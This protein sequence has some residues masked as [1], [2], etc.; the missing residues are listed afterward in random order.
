MTARVLAL[1][2][3]PIIR[4]VHGGQRRV[5]AFKQFYESRGAQYFHA[6][7]YNAAHYSATDV[8]ADDWPL[9]VPPTDTGLANLIGDLMS[10][11][12]FERDEPTLKHFVGVLERID[13]DILQ[14]EHPFMW[15]LARR[16]RQICG[17]RELC[18]VYS[19]HNVEAPLKREILVSQ[20]VSSELRRKICAEI[21]EIEAELCREADLVV[22]VSSA[23]RA[24]YCQSKAPADVVIV[25]NGVDRPPEGSQHRTNEA[26]QRTFEGRRFV[27]TVGS[28]HPPNVDGTCHYLVDGGIFCVPPA[29]SIAVC[30]GV[31]HLLFQRSEFQRYLRANSARVEFFP[32]LDDADLWAIKHACHGVILPLRSGGGSNLKTAEALALGKWTIGTLVALRGYEWLAGA[33]GVIIANDRSSFRHAMRDVLQRPPLQLTEGDRSA[34]EALFWDRCFVDSGVS[35]ILEL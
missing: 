9:I 10:G 26:V 15:P 20:G 19:S 17:N 12:Q 4:P 21:E 24:H 16:L 22:C 35:Q 34:R 14:V 27:M 6:C 31:S 2:T 8:G 7:I 29:K 11:H 33:E 13:P 23:D 25:P 18:L 1:G 3:F 28:A 5:A 30:G 32:D